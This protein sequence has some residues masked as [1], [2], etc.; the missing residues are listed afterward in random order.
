MQ[1]TRGRL[2]DVRGRRGEPAGRRDRCR[3]RD[4]RKPSH[5]ACIRRSGHNPLIDGHR[6]VQPLAFHGQRVRGA[7]PAVR[8]APQREALTCPAPTEARRRCSVWNRFCSCRRAQA[9]NPSSRLRAAQRGTAYLLGAGRA[10]ERRAAAAARG[11]MRSESQQADCFLRQRAGRPAGTCPPRHPDSPGFS[12]IRTT[13]RPG[14]HSRL[15]CKSPGERRH[16]RRLSP[17]PP[18]LDPC[19][20]CRTNVV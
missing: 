5:A 18:F 12:A 4:S 1:R 13:G 14:R 6:R 10:E 7:D 2:P 3:G 11:L 15:P 20:L 19:R 17:T 8:C 9:T 16:L